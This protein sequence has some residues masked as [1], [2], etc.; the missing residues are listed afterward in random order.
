[1]D[2]LTD[3]FNMQLGLQRVVREREG[4]P[5]LQDMSEDDR[6]RSFTDNLAALIVEL[7]EV[8]N[9]IGWKPW[10][11]DRSLDK[12]RYL[13]EMVDVAHFFVNL[14]LIAEITPDEFWL[15]YKIKHQRNM[16]RHEDPANPYTGQKCNFTGCDR[17][18][19]G[20]VGFC[21]HIDRGHGLEILNF[22]S[23][24]HREEW[25]NINL[26]DPREDV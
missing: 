25:L 3:I 9:E 13:G 14:L 1:M 5:Q 26:P 10:A 4:N 2:M 7:G 12:T 21:V 11:T 17:E 20:P 23:N 15:A 6:A 8:S 22:C 18:T 19:D 16:K 24:E